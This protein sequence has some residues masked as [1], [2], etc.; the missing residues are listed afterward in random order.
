MGLLD[1]MQELMDE[2]LFASVI[3]ACI[4]IRQLDQLWS[5]IQRYMTQGGMLALTAPTYGSMI[6]RVHSTEHAFLALK[7]MDSHEDHLHC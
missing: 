1:K 4:R 2:V 5:R 7:V 6:K 3:E